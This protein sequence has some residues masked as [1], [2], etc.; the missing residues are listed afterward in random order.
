[1]T[2]TPTA[3]PP[4][5]NLAIVGLTS[6]I[7]VTHPFVAHQ[8]TV[9]DVSP[10]ATPALPCGEQP[11]P[12]YLITY[13]ATIANH[14]TATLTG[15][16]LT[17]T[18]EPGSE[19]PTV[20]SWTSTDQIHWTMVVGTLTPGQS[21]TETFLVLT[22]PLNVGDSYIV[23]VTANDDGA[24]GPDVNPAGR[25]ATLSTVITVA[26]TQTPV[27]SAT[28]TATPPGGI[29][30]PPPPTSTP[31]G[32]A[33]ALIPNAPTDFTNSNGSVTVVAPVGAVTSD[34]ELIYAPTATPVLTGDMMALQAFDLMVGPVVAPQVPYSA[35]PYTFATPLVITVSYDSTQAQEIDPSTLSFAYLDTN[36]SWIE[37]PSQ[38]NPTTRQVTAAV[39][40]TGRFAVVASTLNHKIF[41]PVV[42]VGAP[43]GW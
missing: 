41:L 24:S 33:V 3:T 25:T 13:F 38:V 34:L 15:V 10:T 36:G 29:D 8:S 20:G 12:C 6:E 28:A 42:P 16:T 35:T 19:F 21:V 43:S 4:F 11:V 39:G 5:V 2:V 27:P 1:M 23:T 9:A 17:A 14:G 30:P 26:P 40:F 37:I 31:A 22:P 32:T 7:Q 18:L